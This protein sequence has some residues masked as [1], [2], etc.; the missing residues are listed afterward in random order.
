MTDTIKEIIRIIGEI[1][2]F[3]TSLFAFRKIFSY[4]GI[5]FTRK[6][7]EAKKL[8][9]YAILIA[10]RNEETVL[11]NLIDSIRQQDY[12]AELID[13]FVVA[14]NCTDNTAQVARDGGAY[15]YERNDKE[16]R[17]KG[18]ALQYLVE[19]IRE[20]FGI[21]SYEGY[22]IFDADNL[23]KQDFV[24][25]MNNSFD[26]GEK[27]VTSYR[28]TKN[29][30]D[31]WISASYGIHWLRSVRTEHRGRSLLHLATRIQGT[32]FLFS[33]EIIKNGWPYTSLTEDRAFC[34]DAVANGYKI[35]YNNKAE[36]FDEQ[37]TDLKIAL[38][39]RLRWAK[40]HL[41]A[42]TET[43]P[44]LLLHV[45]YTGGAANRLMPPG[46]PWWKRLY[47][48]LRLRFMSY[49]MFAFVVPL[50]VFHSFRR[51]LNYILRGILIF[52][53]G[54]YIRTT[55]WGH[56]WFTT[57]FEWIGLDILERE[58]FPALALMLALALTY[59][60]AT[61]IKNALLAAYIFIVE[62]KRIMP[63][64]WYKKIWFCIT[65]PIFDYIGR[66]A[67]LFAL[68]MKIEWKP[69]PHKCNVDI[70]E[71]SNPENVKQE[72]KHEPFSHR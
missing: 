18:F 48:N 30:D 27:I 21:D 35:S 53:V 40:G 66:F 1:S 58:G 38:R 24:R 44:K 3:I 49:D 46:T 55:R 50:T 43:G 59:T 23:L 12:P 20:D 63:I 33:W 7:P 47:N 9:K 31:N 51:L 10:A 2:L 37:P 42:F 6:F 57:L 72:P 54:I 32:G 62:H 8:H 25:H 36:F 17:T 4:I 11:G 67:M 52:T 14:D 56:K 68:F 61:F 28:N 22:F 5:F 60:A 26:A 16:H 70:A 64:K 29:F 65:F 71:L 39:Q 45:F 41:Q 15:C 34:A 13:I 19:C 69:I